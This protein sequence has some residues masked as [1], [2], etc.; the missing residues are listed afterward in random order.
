MIK[1]KDTM[2]VPALRNNLVSVSTIIDNGYTVVFDKYRARIKRKDGSIALTA[3]KKNQLYVVDKINNSAAVTCDVSE[4]KMTRWHQRNGHL[5]IP[6]LKNLKM[7]E[8]V[9]DIDFTIKTDKFQ[10]EI[11]NQ[12]KIHTQPFKP[13]KNRENGILNLIHSDICGPMNVESLGGSRYFVTF[14]DDFSRYTE[15]IML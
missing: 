10:C 14:I 9:K 13:S 3:T 11:C 1:L 6:D 15:I 12:N 7:T 2:H 4:D 5:N 8:M